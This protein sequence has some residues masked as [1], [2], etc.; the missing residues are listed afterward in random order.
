LFTT[1]STDSALASIT[2]P[3]LPSSTYPSLLPKTIY[4]L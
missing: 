3:L 2:I 4:F 1:A